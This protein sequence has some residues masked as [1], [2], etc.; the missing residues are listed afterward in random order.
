M[1]MT[2]RQKGILKFVGLGPVAAVVAFGIYWVNARAGHA[3]HG[4]LLIGLAIPGAYA[5]VGLVEAV[6]GRPF[7]EFAATWDQLRGWQRGVIGIAVA[8]CA[9][10]LFMGIVVAIFS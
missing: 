10:V 8:G 9:F 6:T 2:V 5:L 4:E 1:D 7:R 3:P